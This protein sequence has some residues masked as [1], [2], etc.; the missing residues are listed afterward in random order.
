MIPQFSSI[1]LIY[2]TLSSATTPGQNGHGSDGNKRV[3]SIPHSSSITEASP[4]NCF[5]SYL[6]HSLDKSYLSAE[7]QSV[8]SLALADW[9]IIIIFTQPLRS[10]KIWH[11]VNF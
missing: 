10:G 11:K 3:L 9:A 5:V 8:Y 4:W 2:R 6:W 7:M 1:W